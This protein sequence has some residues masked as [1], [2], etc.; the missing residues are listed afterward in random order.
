[1]KTKWKKINHTVCLIGHKFVDFHKDHQFLPSK[2][3]FFFVRWKIFTFK[4][5]LDR[6]QNNPQRMYSVPEQRCER[7]FFTSFWSQV[8]QNWIIHIFLIFDEEFESG[9]DSRFCSIFQPN[10]SRIALFS[11]CFVYF[12]QEFSNFVSFTLQKNWILF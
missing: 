1:M 3:R 9:I 12:D 11:S 6:K 10:I 2:I 5:L 4:I 8:R 7:K